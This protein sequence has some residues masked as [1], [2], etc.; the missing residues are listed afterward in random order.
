MARANQ[1]TMSQVRQRV[2]DIGEKTK[3]A[4]SDVFESAQ[5]RMS[6]LAQKAEEGFGYVRDAASEYAQQ[7]KEAIQSAGRTV[8]NQVQE[9]PTTALLLAVG[10]GFLLGVIWMRR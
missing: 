10:F 6:D 2:E 8:V 9:R 4:A 3:Q 5:E 1:T 7:G